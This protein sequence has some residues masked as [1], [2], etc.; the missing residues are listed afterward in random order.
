MLTL[1][2]CSTFLPLLLISVSRSLRFLIDNIELSCPCFFLFSG[3]GFEFASKPHF[4]VRYWIGEAVSM[5]PRGARKRKLSQSSLQVPEEPRNVRERSASPGP[6]PSGFATI[7]NA[8]TG[9]FTSKPDPT[10][11]VVGG[12]SDSVTPKPFIGNFFKG[13]ASQAGRIGDNVSL[14]SSFVDMELLHGGYAD[15]KKYQ[16]YITRQ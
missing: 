14:I 9:L 12:A 11:P 16:V 6:G 2:L 5:T 15:D 10:N 13:V 4:L 3:A 7:A 8:V 1:P